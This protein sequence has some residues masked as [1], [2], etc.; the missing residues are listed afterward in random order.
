MTL[1][2]SF[3][4]VSEGFYVVG[5]KPWQVPNLVQNHVK[6]KGVYHNLNGKY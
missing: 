1:K 4:V 3:E 2:D 6:C 5:R